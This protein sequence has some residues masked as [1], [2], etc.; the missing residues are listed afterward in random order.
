MAEPTLLELVKQSLA[1]VSTSTARDTELN[2]LISAAKQDLQ[3]QGININV[4]PSDLI[5]A[6][7]T[8]FVKAN[9]GMLDDRQKENAKETYILLCQNLGLSGTYK[10][11]IETD[12]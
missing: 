12:D 3:R 6:T 1:I 5:N 10:E 11:G 7:I 9:F 2:S 4:T 8:M